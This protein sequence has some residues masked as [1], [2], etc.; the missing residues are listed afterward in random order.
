MTSQFLSV[1]GMLLNAWICIK[2]VCT[3][4]PT[5]TVLGTTTGKD[6]RYLEKTSSHSKKICFHHSYLFWIFFDTTTFIMSNTH[7]TFCIIYCQYRSRSQIKMF[8]FLADIFRRG[9]EPDW[10]WGRPKA[11]PSTSTRSH[12]P[13]ALLLLMESEKN[14]IKR[15]WEVVY[16]WKHTLHV[17]YSH[18]K[19][20]DV[21]ESTRIE[22]FQV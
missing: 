13:G 14:D 21:G 3:S 12:V 6:S 9:G 17:I 19:D 18:L 4:G 20:S 1:L 15:P 16:F 10:T 11:R 22:V 2:M 7:R 5:T 8:I